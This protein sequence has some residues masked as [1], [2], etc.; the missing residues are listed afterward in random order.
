MTLPAH[1]R[2]D[3][4]N[5][6]Q[7]LNSAHRRPNAVSLIHAAPG[8]TRRWTVREV[9]DLVARAAS[10]LRNHGVGEGDHVVC[11]APNDPAHLILA[12]ACQWI[13]AVFVPMPVTAAPAELRMLTAIAEARVYVGTR[14]E[15]AD[16]VSPG[17]FFAAIS[18][19]APIDTQPARLSEAIVAMVFTS[20]S[21]GDPKGVCLSAGALWWSALAFRSGFGYAP[22]SETELVCAPLSHIGGLNGTTLDVLA[23]GGTVVI[24]PRFEPR[25]VLDTIE[26]FR[27]S[28]GF[29]VCVPTMVAGTTRLPTVAARGSVIVASPTRRR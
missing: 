12:L 4:S 27:V 1:A 17:E 15:L 26:R 5:A 25:Q 2:A 18:A 19:V 11:C 13:G 9:A 8:Y 23:G 6:R 14:Q 3:Y 10:W 29:V 22:A 20:G 21:S 24:L 28:M 16:V 7:L